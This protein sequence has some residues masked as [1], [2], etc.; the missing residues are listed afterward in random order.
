[1]K[2]KSA[3]LAF[4]T[5]LML[6]SFVYS[7]NPSGMSGP[8][9]IFIQLDSTWHKGATIV[10]QR[11]DNSGAFKLLANVTTPGNEEEFRSLVKTAAGDFKEAP[12]IDE[13]TIQKWWDGLNSKPMM[14]VYLMNPAGMIAAGAGYY[15]KSAV[16]GMR[17][18]Y[19]VNITAPD[20]KSILEGITGD[21]N[22]PLAISLPKPMF[23]RALED[24]QV[25]RLTWGYVPRKLP[26]IVKVFRRAEGEKEYR[27]IPFNG[28]FS[29]NGDSAFIMAQDT[30]VTSMSM[31]KYF[32]RTSDWLENPF[33]VSDTAVGRAYSVLS[34]PVLR[35]LYTKAV[36]EK[37][38]IRLSWPLIREKEVRGI[39]LFRG[40]SF[41]GSFKHLA[42]L[43]ATD[44]SY[45]DVVPLA[46]E[47]YWYFA[48][49]ANRFGY[50]I[51]SARV[52]DL[53][54]GSSVPMKPLMPTLTAQG[55]NVII[56]WPYNGGI[57][58]GYYLYRG[59]GYRGELKQ[60]SDIIK[61]KE[62]VSYTDS[63]V[64]PG[65]SYNYAIA[66]LGEG[67]G[68]SPLSDA[69]SIMVPANGNV[70]PPYNLSYRNDGSSITLFWE[71]LLVNDGQVSGYNVY[72]KV[73]G[74]E[75]F[76]RLTASPLSALT[77]SY[78][79]SITFGGKTVEY[80]IAS[81]DPNG[82]GSKWSPV[83]TLDIPAPGLV[84][85]EGISLINV[86]GNV[87]IRWPEISDPSLT[88]FKVYRF[89][90]DDEPVLVGSVNASVTSVTDRV[91]LTGNKLNNYYVCAVY[92]NGVESDPGEI[93]SIR[94][95]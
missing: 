56:S 90:G 36:P 54:P 67:T 10:I 52:F 91:P 30:T 2:K 9:G 79:D 51:P 35:M 12:G 95:P 94:I 31:Y 62:L 39:M 6:S 1:M 27:E 86:D 24:N 48:I 58:M 85:V 15:D 41:D 64:I 43:Q 20:G 68:L 19:R 45:M 61:V 75:S 14:P 33:P 29:V 73:S 83:L 18:N 57:V 40:S 38:A 44:T 47:N 26:A 80:A 66:A 46:N 93:L 53:V 28:G 11:S 5:L 77:N 81:V 60:L 8:K 55:N 74:Q 72:R 34:A 82:I 76:S 7:Q 65:N 4:T 21:I 88:G 63:T 17:Y 71:N 37:H 84:K 50:G 78:I 13:Q 89:S 92:S 32:L 49:V 23:I 16:K 69:I 70:T 42:T 25:I 22:F 3:Y 87:L 59:D